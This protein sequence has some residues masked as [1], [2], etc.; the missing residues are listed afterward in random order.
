[1]IEIERKFL[2]ADQGWQASADSGTLL[3]QGYIAISNGNSV[4]V[5]IKGDGSAWLTVKAG[6][7]LVR[8]EYEY[9]VPVAHARRAH[10]IERRDPGAHA[11]RIARSHPH[12]GRAVQLG[13]GHGHART[14]PRVRAH[15][16]G[17]VAA[18]PQIVAARAVGPDWEIH[19][20]RYGRLAS[21]AE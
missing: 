2:V 21:A 1:M 19:V 18:C 17:S 6:S 14:D 20:I 13:H 4:R 10:R 9:S 3:L 8:E 7:G 12:A 16:I 11:L 15:R 5:R